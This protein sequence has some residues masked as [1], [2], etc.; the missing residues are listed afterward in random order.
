M[1]ANKKTCA[2]EIFQG[3]GLRTYY[4]D[5]GSQPKKDLWMQTLQGVIGQLRQSQ[6]GGKGMGKGW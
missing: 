6:G 4:M 3:P 1:M 2:F 5:A